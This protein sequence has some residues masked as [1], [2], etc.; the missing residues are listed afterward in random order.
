MKSIELLNKLTKEQKALLEEAIE[1]TT[2][3]NG[4]VAKVKVKLNEL[5][6]VGK[7]ADWNPI[8]NIF[9]ES[10][11]FRGWWSLSDKTQE[12]FNE[13]FRYLNSLEANEEIR[14]KR[15][16]EIADREHENNQ[17]NIYERM[18]LGAEKI[19]EIMDDMINIEHNLTTS[20]GIEFGLT[21]EDVSKIVKRDFD[22]NL[23]TQNITKDKF[24]RRLEELF[25]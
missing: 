22:F 3:E 7:Y 18:V 5:S 11:C 16:T 12:N 4:D 1:G 14:R 8:P 10:P 23:S 24:S 21:Y 25:G 20:L 9:E 19:E 6:K 2:I 15:L 17:E 13:V